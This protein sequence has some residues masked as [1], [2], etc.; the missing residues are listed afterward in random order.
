[1]Y[2]QSEVGVSFSGTG[3]GRK[4]QHLK[5]FIFDFRIDVD[6]DHQDDA[7]PKPQRWR[8]LKTWHEESNFF[9]WFS[10]LRSLHQIGGILTYAA[11][12]ASSNDFHLWDMWMWMCVLIPFHFSIHIFWLGCRPTRQWCFGLYLRKIENLWQEAMHPLKLCTGW[13]MVRCCWNSVCKPKSWACS[14][15][16][17]P[18]PT[19]LRTTK[20]S[21]LA[22]LDNLRGHATVQ[23]KFD[24]SY[25]TVKHSSSVNDCP[26]QVWYE[27]GWG[28][29]HPS[30]FVPENGTNI[31]FK[32]WFTILIPQRTKRCKVRKSSEVMKL[33]DLRSRC[34]VPMPFVSKRG[35]TVKN[36]CF[37]YRPGTITDDDWWLLG[38]GMERWNVVKR[39]G[40]LDRPACND[41]KSPG[42]EWSHWNAGGRREG[43]DGLGGG[44][45]RQG[46]ARRGKET[47]TR[48]RWIRRHFKKFKG[49]FLF[50]IVFILFILL[51]VHIS[52]PTSHTCSLLS[53]YI[54]SFQLG[55]CID[56]STFNWFKNLLKFYIKIQT[57]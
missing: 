38:R 22:Y 28:A 57:L 46:E 23:P 55:L 17:R 26:F 37:M 34:E 14:D 8:W 10:R 15:L 54:S 39:R 49:S 9:F 20:R 44:K 33:Y 4:W 51:V 50:G 18:A 6:S 19:T 56:S 5:L 13:E 30:E 3:S 27:D 32:H 16:V 25:C 48:T 29:W 35:W 53:R 1:M 52:S 47:S 2:H 21:P 11:D 42:D 31:G 36:A 12:R 7:K 45:E 41:E 43:R 40:D 24:R